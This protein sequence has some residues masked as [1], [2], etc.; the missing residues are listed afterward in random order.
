MSTQAA[1][2]PSLYANVHK[3][4]LADIGGKIGINEK[5]QAPTMEAR[6]K[7]LLKLNSFCSTVNPNLAPST[8]HQ[9]K[10]EFMASNGIRQLGLPCIGCYADLQRPEPLHMEINSWAH[11]LEVMYAEGLQFGIVDNMINV[12]KRPKTDGGVGLKSLGAAMQEHYE[13][14]STRS[15]TFTY[16]LIGEQATT[17]AR[18]ADRIVDLFWREGSSQVQIYR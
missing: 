15:K 13:K 12:F 10:L 1:T 16:R 17:L 14:E 5:W 18:M 2:Y 7:E 11:I 9:K 8:I 3:S 4:E 6:K